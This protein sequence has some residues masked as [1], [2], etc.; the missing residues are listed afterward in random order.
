MGRPA[1]TRNQGYD[2]RRATLAHAVLPRVLADD[3]PR[4]SLHDLAEAAGASVPTLKHYFGTRSGV[5]A[6]ALEGAR[7]LSR[8]HLELAA[9]PSATDL[10]ESMTAFAGSIL[11]A[12]S[13]FGVGRFVAGG[14]AVGIHDAEAGPGYVDGILEPIQQA[15]ERR[16]AVH[17]ARREARIQA[18]EVRA[19]ALA[20]L[21]PLVLALLHQDPLSGRLCRPLDIDA[22]VRTHVEAFVRAWG[23]ERRRRRPPAQSRA[24]PP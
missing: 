3:G 10:G 20:F 7:E 19:A 23:P 21:A 24:A 9:V 17:A 8:P 22:F 14:L 1:G 16:L 11:E 18:H 2:A 13:T 12:W 5:V 15:A 6:A 4:A